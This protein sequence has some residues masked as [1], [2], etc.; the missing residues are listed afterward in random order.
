MNKK[1]LKDVA[2][3]AAWTFFQTFVAVYTIGGI[4]ELKSAVSAALAA[5][6]SVVKTATTAAYNKKYGSK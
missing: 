5:T 4:D 1:V 3:R 6:L 2:E